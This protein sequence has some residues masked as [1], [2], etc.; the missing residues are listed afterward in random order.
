MLYWE[1]CRV[2]YVEETFDE[3]LVG[4]LTQ[5]LKGTEVWLL[6]FRLKYKLI[7]VTNIT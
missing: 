6:N 4:V 1:G 7:S 2:A 3:V 5:G